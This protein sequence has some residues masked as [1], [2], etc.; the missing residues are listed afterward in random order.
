MQIPSGAR[1]LSWGLRMTSAIWYQMEGRDLP[2][3]ADYRQAVDLNR[4][5]AVRV[6]RPYLEAQWELPLAL[7]N[8]DDATVT[9]AHRTCRSWRERRDYPGRICFGQNGGGDDLPGSQPT[10]IQPPLPAP[11]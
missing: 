2:D 6:K 1:S 4:P 9:S 10:D 5:R 3:G 7:C 11:G 8:S